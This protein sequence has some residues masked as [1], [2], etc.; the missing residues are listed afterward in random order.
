[1][2]ERKDAKKYNRIKLYIS[3]SQIFIDLLFW[4]FIISLNFNYFFANLA[5]K[6]CSTD[7]SQFYIFTLIIGLLK[8]TL[9]LPFSFYSGFIIE[10][11][12]NLTNQKLSSWI[13]EQTKGLL[14]GIILGFIVLTIFYVI[15]LNYPD[16][17]WIWVWLFILLFGILLSHLAPI[18]I[19]PLFYKFTPL[20]NEKLAAR[21]KSFA[22]RWHFKVTGIFQFNLSKTTKKANAAFTG[23]GKSKRIILGDTLLQNFTEDEIESIFAHEIGHY[24]YHHLLKGIFFSSTLSFLGIFTVFKIYQMTTTSL[25]LL[26][27]QLEALP[28]LALLF[29]LYSILTTP[30][31]NY[32]SRKFEYQADQFAV[33]STGNPEVFKRSLLKLAELNLADRD[34]HPIVEILFYSHPSI[35]HRIEKISRALQ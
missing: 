19:F 34:P 9:D 32:I 6:L 10:K 15:L 20:E 30:L 23:I 22:E 31:G 4:L 16:S 7:L 1:M 12:F 13:F 25:D 5:Y 27:H 35:K 33:K 17:W 28:Y 3:L 26:P 21:I 14:I 24:K 8:F 11:K 29:Y 2:I 18:I